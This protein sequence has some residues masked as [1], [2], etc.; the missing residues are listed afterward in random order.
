[1]KKED[2]KDDRKKGEPSRSESSTSKKR[3]LD[4][5]DE[6]RSCQ[7]TDQVTF[8]SDVTLLS[9]GYAPGNTWVTGAASS[10][11]TDPAALGACS[12]VAVITN[13][14]AEPSGIR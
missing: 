5:A 14:C 13:A 6:D 12:Q 4:V 8:D 7:D 9:L 11:V 3:V 1:M 10:T 2:E